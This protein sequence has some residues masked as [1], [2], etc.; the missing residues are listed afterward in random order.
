M[1]PRENE[2]ALRLEGR[3]ARN[4]FS[5][6]AF[7]GAEEV[8]FDTG[9]GFIRDL[10]D[11]RFDKIAH[12]VTLRLFCSRTTGNFGCGSVVSQRRNLACGLSELSSFSRTAAV[13]SR[14]LVYC[15]QT[16]QPGS[17]KMEILQAKPPSVLA[18][19]AQLAQCDFS[20]G[21]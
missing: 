8:L 9:R 21:V 18:A 11:V 10:D 1:D 5:T 7:V 19:L 14:S 3:A 4:G 16:R 12:C 6:P 13:K 15:D 20:L 17:D 2:H